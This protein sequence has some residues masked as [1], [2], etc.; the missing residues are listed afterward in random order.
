MGYTPRKTVYRLTR[1]QLHLNKAKLWRSKFPDLDQQKSCLA[2]QPF[3]SCRFY[4]LCATG[5]NIR[6]S[7][8]N[9]ALR[10][11]KSVRYSGVHYSRVCFHIFY[12]NS[13][14]LSNVVHYNGVF[15]TV[16]FIIAGCHCSE[17]CYKRLNTASHKLWIQ[18]P[19]TMIIIDWARQEHYNFH[20][21]LLHLISPREMGV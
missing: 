20:Y 3:V 10:P 7:G 19:G 18:N 11:S 12:C 9:C 2:Y 6:Y 8:V 5:Q 13:A 15:V 21:C 1:E 17:Q 16:R 14:G 4:W